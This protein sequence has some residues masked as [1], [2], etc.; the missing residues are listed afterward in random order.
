[1]R[2]KFAVLSLAVLLLPVLSRAQN[3]A[4]TTPTFGSNGQSLGVGDK[5]DYYLNETYLNSSV[6]TAPAFRAGIRMA[7]PPGR[8]VTQYPP[9]WRQGSEAFGRNY[10]DAFAERVTFQTAR[11]ATGVITHEDPRYVPSSSRNFFAR[12]AHALAFTIVDR[13]D[14]GHAMPAISN[15]VGATAAG[16]VGNSYLPSGLNDATHAGQRATIRLGFAAAGNLF[17]EFAPQ[18]PRPVR[19]VLQLIAR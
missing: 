1:M 19:T 2:L 16:F 6:F 8:G 3:P 11:F 12:S 18:M 17:R 4:A 10:G 7:N 13:S 5:F 15:F 9:E 14:S